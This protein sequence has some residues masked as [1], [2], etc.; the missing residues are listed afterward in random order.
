MT[1]ILSCM[2]FEKYVDLYEKYVDLYFHLGIVSLK[3]R[4]LTLIII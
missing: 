2:R 1:N 3:R 4:L